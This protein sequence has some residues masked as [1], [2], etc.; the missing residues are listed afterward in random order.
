M[1]NDNIIFINRGSIFPPLFKGN[2]MIITIVKDY[3]KVGENTYG[4]PVIKNQKDYRKFETNLQNDIDHL[5]L[6]QDEEGYALSVEIGK[7]IL[8]F[9]KPKYEK[10]ETK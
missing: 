7:A 4:I 3:S 1:W 2:E 6:Y 10:G 9:Y 5:H 8:N